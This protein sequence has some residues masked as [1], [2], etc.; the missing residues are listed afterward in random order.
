[1]LKL[2]IKKDT[3]VKLSQDLDIIAGGVDH[4]STE[5]FGKNHNELLQPF[6][7]TETFGKMK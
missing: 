5:T 2:G 7:S 4:Y 3:L 6:I 1:M